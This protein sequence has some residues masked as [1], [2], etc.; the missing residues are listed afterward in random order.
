MVG[1]TLIARI[2]GGALGAL[3]P[4]IALAW[5]DRPAYGHAMANYALALLLIG[6]IAQYIGQGYMRDLVTGA[7]SLE[8]GRPA[9]TAMVHAYLLLC[10]AG[11]ALTGALSVLSRVD[12]GFTVA[13]VAVVAVS[14]MQE[15][16]FVAVGRQASAIVLFYI[17]PPL[18]HSV[19]MM[20]G[21][22]FVGGNDF[23]IVGVAHVI[24]LAVCVAVSLVV[25]TSAGRRL[26]LPRFPCSLADW[27]QEFSAAAVFM[28]NG[29]VLSATENLPVVLLR[30]L[31]FAA[32]IPIFELA[33]KV[34]AIPGLLIHALN[35]HM[36]PRL[37]AQANVGLWREFRALLARFTLLS[38]SIGGAYVA[39]ALIAL[40]SAPDVPL[41]AERVD[42]AMFAILLMSALVTALAAPCGS[43]LIALRGEIWWTVGAVGSFVV[44]VAITVAALSRSGPLAIPIAVVGQTAA[45]SA[46]VVLG[47][48]LLLAAKSRSPAA[49]DGLLGSEDARTGRIVR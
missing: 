29:V 14:R 20:A 12:T 25:Q 47:S 16:W 39:V 10:G 18:L 24:A 43:A 49:I 11:I 34:A 27:R 41:L 19:F 22:L 5:L 31:G 21:W 37:I 8:A 3:P 42:T 6:P 32:L 44:Q 7:S 33:R 23:W 1:A 15:S 30:A 36:T 2:A 28:L 35:M 40:L 45:L 4:I 9:G 17:L 38:A 46:T 48:M 26:L 13:F